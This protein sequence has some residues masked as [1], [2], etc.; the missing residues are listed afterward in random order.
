MII[1]DKGVADN[2][3]SPLKIYYA[4]NKEKQND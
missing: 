3:P 2:K 1:K 4:G